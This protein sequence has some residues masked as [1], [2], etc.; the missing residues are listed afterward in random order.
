MLKCKKPQS[1]NYHISW[2]A[3]VINYKL[4]LILWTLRK[5]KCWHVNNNALIFFFNCILVKRVLFRITEIVLSICIILICI[6]NRKY[7]QTKLVHMFLNL[8]CIQ[9]WFFWIYFWFRIVT[10]SQHTTLVTVLSR[11]LMIQ[12]FL[13]LF[14]N[15]LQHFLLN[16]W[17]HF[18]TFL[19]LV[20]F[21][22]TEEFKVLIQ[23]PGFSLLSQIIFKSSTSV[24]YVS[25]SE[26]CKYCMCVC[27]W[28]CLFTFIH[29]YLC[30]WYIYAYIH[31]YILYLIA[32]KY[33]Q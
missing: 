3:D 24:R 22:S 31:V 17:W 29:I 9:R 4:H 14:H 27:G 15:C 21:W 16:H 8:L 18:Y 20:H 7:E 25:I 11:A 23:Q 12:H 30:M 6:H 26:I 28:M 19:M 13:R 2:T 32:M 33:I 10:E 5:K 1:I